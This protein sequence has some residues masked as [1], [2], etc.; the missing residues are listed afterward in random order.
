MPAEQYYTAEDFYTISK[1]DAHVHYNSLSTELTDLAEKLN[2]RLLSINTNIPG[3]PSIQ[4]QQNYVVNHKAFQKTLFHLTSFDST[5]VFQKN[6]QQDQLDYLDSSFRKGALGFKVWKDIGMVLQN[7]RN[8]FVFIDDDMFAP[9]FDYAQRNNLPVLGHMG[10]PRN[11]WLPLEEMTVNNDRNYFTHHP[12]Y[13]MHLHPECPAYSKLTDS[14]ESMLSK[15]PELSYIGAHFGSLEWSTDEVAKRF[16]KFPE[17]AADTAERMGHM[18][19]QTIADRDKVRNFFV[20]YH[21]RI[22]YGTDI[23]VDNDGDFSALTKRVTEIWLN[24]WR[25]LTTDDELTSPYVNESFRGLKLPK[26]VVDSIYSGNAVH[27]YK[28]PAVS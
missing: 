17:M 9:F 28:M 15:H 4:E 8:E 6:W 13:H 19:F 26:D 25:Y 2:F 18:H 27:W 22:L 23:I 10:E 14:Y 24:D 12:E 11:C 20:Q 16:Q 5:N 7:V 21:D 3:F 1:V